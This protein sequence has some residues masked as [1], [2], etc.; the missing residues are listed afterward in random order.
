M[1]RQY[2]VNYKKV[3]ETVKGN[4]TVFGILISF[5]DKADGESAS[6]DLTNLQSALPIV[7]IIQKAFVGLRKREL[8]FEGFKIRFIFDSGA[9]IGSISFQKASSEN[10]KNEVIKQSEGIVKSPYRLKYIGIVLVRRNDRPLYKVVTKMTQDSSSEQTITYVVS[11]TFVSTIDNK[12][13]VV[14]IVLPIDVAMYTNL[15]KS[16]LEDNH[17]GILRK[18][19]T[20][21]FMQI[22]V[23]GSNGRIYGKRAYSPVKSRNDFDMKVKSSIDAL[24]HKAEEYRE[25][26]ASIMFDIA[27]IDLVLIKNKAHIA[28][29]YVEL[30]ESLKTHFR[31]NIKTRENCAFVA[32][33]MSHN[34]LKGKYNYTHRNATQAGS[35]LKRTMIALKIIEEKDFASVDDIV[36]AANQLKRPIIIYD[37]LMNILYDG[38]TGPG[39]APYI[40]LQ[41]VNGHAVSLFRYSDFEGDEK[42]KQLV[43]SYEFDPALASMK[44]RISSIS[45]IDTEA[46]GYSRDDLAS[47]VMEGVYKPSKE[48][49]YAGY[50]INKLKD[51]RIP[52]IRKDKYVTRT[53]TKSVNR[54]IAADAETV[55]DENGVAR[56]ILWGFYYIAPEYDEEQYMYWQGPDCME[57]FNDWLFNNMHNLE[58][59]TMYAH[60]GGRFDWI[61]LMEALFK[62]PRFKVE[63]PIEIGQSFVCMSIVLARP[64]HIPPDEWRK[65]GGRYR[66]DVRDSC[67]LILPFALKRLLDDFKCTTL[68]GEFDHESHNKAAL[69]YAK[70]TGTS[71]HEYYKQYPTVRDL[72]DYHKADCM[73]LYE[74]VVK[75]RDGLL[76]DYSLDMSK[77]AT[78]ASISKIVQLAH[79]YTPCSAPTLESLRNSDNKQIKMRLTP[80]SPLYDPE[81]EKFIIQNEEKARLNKEKGLKNYWLAFLN[82]E[83]DRYI[84][85]SY[86]GGRVECFYSP[87]T[88]RDKSQQTPL[89][90]MFQKA[91]YYDFTSLFPDV[92]RNDLP[93]NRPVYCNNKTTIE[94]IRKGTF[95]GFVHC[96][97]RSKKA[98]ADAD[99]ECNIKP[100][101]GNKGA[102]LTFQ[103]YTDWVET[104][105]FSEEIYYADSLTVTD[106]E[107]NVIK[108]MYDYLI[109]DGLHFQKGPVLRHFFE[110]MC[111]RKI[112][113]KKE[114]N[115]CGE[116]INKNLANSGYGFWALRTKERDGLELHPKESTTWLNYLNQGKL[117][118]QNVIGTTRIVRLLKDLDTK[119]FNVAIASA[120]TSYARMKLHRLITFIHKAGYK[121]AYCDTDSVICNVDLL[122][123]PGIEQFIPEAP[124]WNKWHD[125]GRVGPQPPVPGTALGSLKNEYEADP[126]GYFHTIYIGNPKFYGLEGTHKSIYKCKGFAGKQLDKTNALSVQLPKYARGEI[127][128]LSSSSFSFK[129]GRKQLLNCMQMQA[130]KIHRA[131]KGMEKGGYYKGTLSGQ[132]ILPYYD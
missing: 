102:R 120:I 89:D 78:T 101:H 15:L 52:F 21:D 87:N 81:Y 9:S 67:K 121:V 96:R 114:G 71:F 54:I 50:D 41:L 108:G 85:A 2:L 63:R 118:D 46:T 36:K 128:Y 53:F 115:K 75:F 5:T 48:N 37:G 60:N 124:E 59:Y 80:D 27:K 106:K 110:D 98:F 68:K 6:I 103:R 92:G 122:T 113:A 30:K 23:E 28:K 73:G 74:L 57:R 33:Q 94:A 70:N 56:P 72:L 1:Q 117:L 129:S 88:F 130:S 35:K 97:I 8:P 17:K 26:D 86:F 77:I 19:I 13:V 34:I 123:L 69:E 100:V 4:S 38:R 29:G 49:I 83:Q 7:R 43:A 11:N 24:L 105:L 107:G 40:E 44:K 104:T 55:N 47:V 76:K 127:E 25:E 61:L 126:K 22:R 39:R 109:L 132:T 125:S 12:P 99:P 66:L 58:N 90:E 14:P 82:E 10:I 95:F 84:R 20:F 91:Y 131:I 45:G 65:T 32:L 112:Q 3:D 116:A 31:I 111:Q 18:G 64:P 62:D 51:Q 119:D 42:F 93:H 79:Y 16:V